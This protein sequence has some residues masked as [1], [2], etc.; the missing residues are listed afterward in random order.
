M[1]DNF[2]RNQVVSK[3]AVH[4]SR[5]IVVAQHR[6]A[7]EVGAQVLA[8]G[9]DCVD[10]VVATSFA[11]GAVE[12]WMSGVGGGG[13]MVLYRA[14]TDTVEVIDF[15]MRSPSGMDA[16]DYPLSGA[17][18]SADLFPWPRVVDDRNVHGAGSIAV[19]GTVAG[20]AMAHARH[21]RMPWREL[22]APAA[23][24]ARR[25]LI[26]DW[27]ATDMI[28]SGAPDLRRYPASADTYLVDG[29]PPTAAW[30]V[31]TEVRMPQERLA[32]TLG[33]LATAGAQS[34]YRGDLARSIAADVRA[35]G[36]YLAEADLAGY[37]AMPRSA[38]MIPYRGGRVYATPELTAGPTLAG[39]LRALEAWQ[40]RGPAPD[41]A[42]YAAFARAIQSGYRTRL[43]DM[44]DADG[45]RAIGAEHLAPGCTSHFSVVDRHGN[46][47]AVTQ[48]LLSIFGSRYVLP[49][50]G[51]LMNNGILWFDTEPGKTNSLAGGKRCL[52]NYTP[53][54]A[55]DARGARIALGA[56]GGRRILPAVA[57]LLSFTHDYE[58]DLQTAFHMPRIDASEGATV[59]ADLR[60]PAAV[61][62]ALAAE[63]ETVDAAL[64]TLPM[65]FACPSAV[66][67]DKSGNSGATEIF[68]PWAEAVA[69]GTA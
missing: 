12:P 23:A 60:L 8:A 19:P 49:S 32:A 58:M 14:A 64:Q 55:A 35:G 20:M 36:G 5:G 45:R 10:A 54:I 11:L 40:P 25:G 63:F 26:V 50:S 22:V 47:A 37:A 16:R 62:A 24:L 28:A 17:G 31:R 1:A 33:E 21:A 27:F 41:A 44:G 15:G 34:F 69:E 46:M 57:Q 43:A 53:V 13:A 42:A 67:R 68:L 52:T 48:T 18:A 7:A 56:S 29:L 59:I 2:S 6:H 30:G 3:P 51:I 4:S 39:V 65:K 38:L 9:G 66:A 61:R